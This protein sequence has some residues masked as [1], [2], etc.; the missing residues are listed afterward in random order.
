MVGGIDSHYFQEYGKTQK[1][2]ITRELCRLLR[3]GVEPPPLAGHSG[4][5][6]PIVK[7]T[8]WGRFNVC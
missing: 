7:P 4:D 5:G 1:N 2:N 8:S 6:E 3:G